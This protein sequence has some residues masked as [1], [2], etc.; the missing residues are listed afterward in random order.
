[1]KKLP[2][3]NSALKAVLEDDLNKR[4][5]RTDFRQSTLFRIADL[6]CVMQIKL[7][8]A[9]KTKLGTKSYE[10]NLVALETLNLAFVMMTDLQGENLL[11]RNE[12]LT[13][14]HEAEII[15]A[16]LTERVKTLEMIDD[17]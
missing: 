17:L 3:S 14:R 13:L 7:L 11:L 15:I 2:E 12:L 10:D 4:I 8:E 16:E 1:M 6:L 5:P 9:N